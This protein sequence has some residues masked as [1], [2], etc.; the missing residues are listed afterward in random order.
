MEKTL[1]MA[2]AIKKRASLTDVNKLLLLSFGHLSQAVVATGQVSLQA[3][4]SGHNHALHLPAFRAR[5]CRGQ[6]QS[7]DA[8][9]GADT[10]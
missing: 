3:R 1:S 7:T 4:Q 8:A 2:S 10:T 6:T 5:A 9:T